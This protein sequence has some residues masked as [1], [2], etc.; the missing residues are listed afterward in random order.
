MLDLEESLL[1]VLRRLGGL[2]HRSGSNC[3][4][5]VS[6]G[7]FLGSQ[8]SQTTTIQPYQ[9]SKR[10]AI[11]FVEHVLTYDLSGTH[12]A[13]LLSHS[14]TGLIMRCPAGVV[15]IEVVIRSCKMLV[16]PGWVPD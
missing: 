2:G 9:K 8:W 1:A 13:W 10:V 15:Y 5:S 4:Q 12:I 6:D 16:F 7:E 3:I 14:R 11:A